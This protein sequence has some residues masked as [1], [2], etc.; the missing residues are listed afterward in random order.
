VIRCPGCAE[1]HEARLAAC[2]RCGF[3]PREI[4]GHVAWAP[5]LAFANTGFEPEYFENL[6]RLEEGNFWFRARN[7][8]VT[9]ALRRYF[10]GLRSFL[11][12]GCGT[13][14]VASGVARAFPGARLVGTEIYAAGLRHAARRNPGAEF[15]QMDAR[16][17][18][19][20]GEFDVAGAFDVIEH[21]AED[22]AVLANLRRAVR[23]GG[24]VL[25]TVPQHPSLW[26]ASDEYARHVRRYTAREIHRKVRAAGLEVVRSTSFVT[27]PLPAMLVSRR[28]RRDLAT[29]DPAAE[30]TMAKPLDRALEAVLGIERA[31]IR[32][33]VS[34]PAGGSRLVVARRS[35]S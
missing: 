10:A 21:I 29:F 22:E 30:L 34:L 23:P 9:W 24:G 17:I 14:Y 5:E 15:V 13:G 32:A 20:E 25:L 11:E 31:A 19:Y 8:L 33:G 7:A 28:A 16:N 4:E 12:I 18:P 3:R 2:P 6:V 1:L 26:S 27:L 35:D